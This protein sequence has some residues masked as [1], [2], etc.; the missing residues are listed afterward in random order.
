M[1]IQRTT[2]VYLKYKRASEAYLKPHNRP[3]KA[4]IPHLHIT[5]RRFRQVR[6]L[7]SRRHSRA[8]GGSN[9]SLCDFFT[10]R[11]DVHK[12]LKYSPAGCFRCVQTSGKTERWWSIE[13]IYKNDVSRGIEVST[14]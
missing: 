7:T 8:T 13:N 10:R 4:H 1:A 6:K 9:V 2:S 3:S 5:L 12:S 11:Y 14:V